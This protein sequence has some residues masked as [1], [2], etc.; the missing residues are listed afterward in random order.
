MIKVSQPQNAIGLG[1]LIVVGTKVRVALD[2]FGTGQSSLAYLASLPIDIIKI[3]RSFIKAAT[4]DEFARTAIQTVVQ[5]A[6]V[7]KAKTVAE[8]I[9]TEEQRAIASAE[10]C[11]IFQGFLGSPPL[12]AEDFRSLAR[13]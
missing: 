11:E 1:A 2:D 9:E 7:I 10:G 4:T 3:D 8:G 12:A 6:R 13:A 5:L